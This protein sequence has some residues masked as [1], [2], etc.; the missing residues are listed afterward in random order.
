[1]FERVCERPLER[2]GLRYH[3]ATTKNSL[4]CPTIKNLRVSRLEREIRMKMLKNAENSNFPRGRAPGPPRELIVLYR[5]PNDVS[6]AVCLTLRVLNRLYMVQNFSG[7]TLS[8]LYF[9]SRCLVLISGKKDP[10][11]L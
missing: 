6:T 11:I 9:Y 4:T 7:K 10:I 5:Q 3:I 8:E 2:F 1:M